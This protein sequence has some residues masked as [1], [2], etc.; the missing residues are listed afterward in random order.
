MLGS[1]YNVVEAE[2]AVNNLAGKYPALARSILLPNKTSEGRRSHALH[3][4]TDISSQRPAVM[5]I[6]AVHGNEWAG[7][8][9]AINLAADVLKAYTAATPSDLVY[10]GK[11][12][13][14]AQIKSLLEQRD[15]VIFP[16]VNPDG[17]AYSQADRGIR[18]WRKNRRP[19]NG[20]GVAFGV[21]INRNYDLLFDLEAFSRQAPE[22]AG[23]RPASR[24]YQGEVALSEPE[25]RNVVWLLDTF[26]TIGWFVDLHCTGPEIR[27]VWSVDDAGRNCEENFMNPLFDKQRGVAGQGY[28]EFLDPQDEQAMA[29]LACRF[30]TDVAAV[31]GTE[32]KSGPGF[33]HL[34]TAGTGHDYAYSRH[35]R[36]PNLGKI[37]SFYVEWGDG[38]DQPDS[39]DVDKIIKEVSAGLIGMCLAT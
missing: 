26:P 32:Y 14:T 21:D 31:H 30:V 23:T 7:C 20:D 4:S 22:A 39:P 35:R 10:G 18:T 27:Y 34:P 9:I 16:L 28:R 17:R 29:A 1:Y 12:F 8:E 3:I 19:P 6:A 5:I 33:Q 25:T 13:C 37:L 24:F 2:A 11:E 38:D 36:N 15:L